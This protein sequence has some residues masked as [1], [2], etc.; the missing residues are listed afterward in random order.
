MRKEEGLLLSR[1]LLSWHNL[2]YVV[3]PVAP[4]DDQGRPVLLTPPL[5]QLL[6]G[7]PGEAGAGPAL[8]PGR[9]ASLAPG[10]RSP[11]ELLGQRLAELV[12]YQDKQ[13]HS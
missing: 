4:L 9:G 7:S 3:Y 1:A 13:G 2:T 8:D 5:D 6:Q 10:P 12:P 11:L